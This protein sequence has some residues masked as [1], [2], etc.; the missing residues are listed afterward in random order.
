M[1]VETC[2][3]RCCT[4]PR[5]TGIGPGC[6]LPVAV[7]GGCAADGDE[8][9]GD[10]A[11]EARDAGGAGAA[12]ATGVGAD[13]PFVAGRAAGSGDEGDEDGGTGGCPGVGT[14]EPDGPGRA[15]G[16]AE[17]NPPME[18]AAAECVPPGA[19][20]PHTSQ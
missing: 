14:G 8:G 4:T 20:I 17:G 7:A 13:A 3:G 15:A 16:V 9:T 1:P 10:G 6:T 2:A 18:A 11:D 12:D 19:G 5:P